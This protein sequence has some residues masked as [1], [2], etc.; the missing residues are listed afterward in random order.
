MLPE[1]M[2]PT[3][4]AGEYRGLAPADRGRRPSAVAQRTAKV[5]AGLRPWNVPSGMPTGP[6][7]TVL[8]GREA[9]LARLAPALPV[10]VIAR[11]AVFAAPP[12]ACRSP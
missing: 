11:L 9:R 7:S 8:P 12:R 10:S 2:K 1:P 6:P 3:C 4:M 5:R